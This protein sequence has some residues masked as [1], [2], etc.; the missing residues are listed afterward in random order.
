MAKTGNDANKKVN[1]ILK[2]HIASRTLENWK[3]AM[4][5]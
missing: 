5:K 3:S 4:W 2:S 1:S